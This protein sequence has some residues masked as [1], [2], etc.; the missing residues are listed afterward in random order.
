MDMNVDTP[1]GWCN[2]DCLYGTYELA[3]QIIH[4]IK[5]CIQAVA[6]KKC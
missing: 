6:R 5:K 2:W 1:E 4:K 3:L